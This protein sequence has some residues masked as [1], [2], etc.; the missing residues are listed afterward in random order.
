MTES[1]DGRQLP[2]SRMSVIT[3][4]K[5]WLARGSSMAGS[6]SMNSNRSIQPCRSITICTYWAFSYTSSTRIYG[7]IYR[8]VNLLTGHSHTRPARRSTDRIR[9]VVSWRTYVKKYTSYGI[10]ADT[11]LVPPTMHHAALRRK[12]AAECP[13]SCHILFLYIKISTRNRRP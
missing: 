2:R 11:R 9:A 3:C 13:I 4:L 1:P 7:Q 5:M 8:A 6:R 10:P 12:C